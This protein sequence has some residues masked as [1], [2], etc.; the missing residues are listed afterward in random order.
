[1]TREQ[2]HPEDGQNRQRNADGKSDTAELMAMVYDELRRLAANRMKDERIG[3]TLQPTALVHE[4]YLKLADLTRIKWSN[5]VHFSVA[6]AEAIRR[7]L[8]DHARAK[9]T[10]KRGRDRK[11]VTL[12]GLEDAD[13]GFEVDLL[14]L[15]DLMHRLAELAPRKAR[16]VELRF[17]GGLTIEQTAEALNVSTTTIE[18]DW[19]F[20]RSW[21]R[22]ELG[23]DDVR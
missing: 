16:V 21:L 2:P 20:A 19:A 17:F 22:R 3:H 23:A 9:E 13:G 10:L 11:R 18:S 5:E 6:A 14:A 1:M 4:A 8:V 7:V 15:D 12:S